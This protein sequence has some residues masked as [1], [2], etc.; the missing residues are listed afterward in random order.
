M[1]DTALAGA[2]ADEAAPKRPARTARPAAKPHGQWKVDGT[3]PLNANE[4]WKQEDNGLNVRERIESVYSKHGFDSIDGTDLHGRFRWWGLYTQRKPGIDGGK[5]ATLEPHE[6]E[7]KYFMLRVRI[8]GGALTTEQLRVIGQISV[9]F[10]R[11]S[12]DLTDRQNIQLHW[13]RVEDVPEIWRRLESVGL[14]TTEACGDVPRVILGSPVAGIAKDEIIDPTPLIHE[15]A[16]RFIGDPEL[17]NL[18][19]KYKTAITGHPSQ[20]VV[21]EINDFGLVGMVHPELGVGYDLWVGGALSTNPMLAKRLG[22]F[23]KP[24]EAAEVWLGV[25]SIFRDYGYRRMRTKARLKFLLADW[26]PEKFRQIL[27]DEYLG[28]KLSDGPAAPKPSTPGD[29]VGIH[30][31]KDGKFFIGATPLAGRL[32]GSQLVKLADTLE[33]RGSFRLRTTPH[34]KIVVLDVA[35]EQVEALVAELDTL[36]LSARPSVFRRGTIACT[37]IEFCKLAIVETKVTAATAVAELERRLADLADSGQ[38]P[39]ALSLHI[40]GCPNSCARIQTADIGLKGMM[41][42]TPDG[43]PTPGFQV[44]LGGGLASSSRE[45]AG[46]GRT[47]RGLKVYVEDLPDYVERVVRKFVADRAEGQTFAEWAHSADEGDLQ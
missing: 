18:P 21:H 32:S 3:A 17:A 13:I 11:G 4:T 40:N 33:A 36:G 9:D 24:E 41:L 25:T 27:E 46:L 10:A 45:E 16:E 44:H 38:L 19:R 14:S 31:Q 34:Q 15:L 20:D 23:V 2:S 5:T 47:V 35:K 1:T 22:A 29:H 26:G 7:D 42:P 28:F 37:G 8:D 6:L 12:A 39:Q 30:E 43:D